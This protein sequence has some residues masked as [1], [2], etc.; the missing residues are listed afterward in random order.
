M[1]A[2]FDNF[3]KRTL[4]ERSDLIKYQGEKV[5]VDIV[6]V[7]DDLERAI[8]FSGADPEKL[9]SGLELIR[10]NFV[11]RL[12]KWEVRSESAI[13]ADFDPTKHAA[14][15]QIASEGAKVGAVIGELK[16]AYFY[17]DKLLRPAEVVVA[18]AVEK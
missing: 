8:E 18:A 13:G 5:F 10:K 1:L 3:K 2:D 16:K 14:I 15:S 17:K 11:E 7:L 4:K 6:E 12:G 9:K